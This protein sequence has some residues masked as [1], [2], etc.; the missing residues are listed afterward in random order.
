MRVVVAQER[1]AG[2]GVKRVDHLPKRAALYNLYEPN[3]TTKLHNTDVQFVALRALEAILDDIQ[4]GGS[5]GVTRCCRH[6]SGMMEALLGNQGTW[7]H[8]LDSVVV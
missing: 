4:D 7:T 3:C 5:A 8:K 6:L 2:N 1:A